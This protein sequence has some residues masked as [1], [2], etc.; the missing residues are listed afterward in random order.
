MIPGTARARMC[1]WALV[2]FSAR[3]CPISMK[4]ACPNLPDAHYQ[5]PGQFIKNSHTKC[6]VGHTLLQFDSNATVI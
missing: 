6:F 5:M 3:M 2:N 4:R 1:P